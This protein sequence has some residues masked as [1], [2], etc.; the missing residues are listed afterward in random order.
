VAAAAL[1]PSAAATG[2]QSMTIMSP[3]SPVAPPPVSPTVRIMAYRPQ[4]K[5]WRDRSDVAGSGL[6]QGMPCKEINRQQAIFE[7]ID[8]EQ[9]YLRDV[10]TLMLV[11]EGLG[12]GVGCNPSNTVHR[13]NRFTCCHWKPAN[14][15]RFNRSRCVAEGR[16]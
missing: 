4:G 7:L 11:R 3:C 8:S 16:S 1:T 10:E 14:C 9:A 2:N 6:L 13:D 5:L 15:P 12:C